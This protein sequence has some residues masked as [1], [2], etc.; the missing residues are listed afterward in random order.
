MLRGL[1]RECRRGRPQEGCIGGHRLGRAGRF[2][3]KS[4]PQ[5]KELDV[6]QGP[7]ASGTINK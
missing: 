4:R 3:L 2:R 5:A 1:D 6:G 7:G